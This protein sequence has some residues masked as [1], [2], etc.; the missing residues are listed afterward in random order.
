ME[1]NRVGH[2]SALSSLSALAQES[3]LEVFRLLVQAGA[4]GLPA[5]DI[6]KRLKIPASSL[7]FHLNNLA[8]GLLINSTREGRS[9]IYSAN[10]DQMRGL[11]AYL[12]ENCCAGECGAN[13]RDASV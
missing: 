6:A 5:G 3:R 8:Q 1:T 7:S 11:V 9:I 12:L 10:F 2:L 4:S 13:T